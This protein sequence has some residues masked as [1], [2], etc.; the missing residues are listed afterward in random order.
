MAAVAVVAAALGGPLAHRQR[1]DQRGP[2]LRPRDG[3]Q[4]QAGRRVRHHQ[5]VVDGGLGGLA[6]V[7]VEGV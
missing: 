6:P 2:E 5:Q 7:K 4:R 3:E 1:V